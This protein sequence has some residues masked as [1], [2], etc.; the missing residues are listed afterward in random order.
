[1]HRCSP[2]RD[3]SD[4][5]EVIYVWKGLCVPVLWKSGPARR[6]PA[7]SVGNA[8]CK[9]PNGLLCAC[10]VGGSRDLR[11][12]LELGG[13]DALIQLRAIVTPAQMGYAYFCVP[14]CTHLLMSACPRAHTRL[15]LHAHVHTPA[16]FCAHTCAHL[17]M[18]LP[19][20]APYNM[21]TCKWETRECVVRDI[22]A[23]FAKCL[24][25]GGRAHT[26]MHMRTCA[27]AI[28]CDSRAR[29]GPNSVL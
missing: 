26:H 12:K 9:P 22:H 11:W 24:Q 16:Y 27:Q 19:E 13:R 6:L 5:K 1:M 7:L 8:C 23:W 10:R 4:T 14:T 21:R 2:A 17:C 3:L 25:A 18:H 29:D 15:F 20:M 28:I